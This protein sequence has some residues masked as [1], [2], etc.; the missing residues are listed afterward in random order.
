[1]QRTMEFVFLTWKLGDSQGGEG[2]AASKD[3]TAYLIPNQASSSGVVM[4]SGLCQDHTGFL[5]LPCGSLH[6]ADA[7][8]R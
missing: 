6:S 2:C 7:Q 8:P 5:R 4:D 1:M 3:P